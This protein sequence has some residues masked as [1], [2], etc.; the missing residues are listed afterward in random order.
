MAEKKGGGGGGGRQFRSQI[1]FYYANNGAR[2]YLAPG[3]N[4]TCSATDT[5]FIKVPFQGGG[6]SMSPHPL[7]SNLL[8]IHTRLQFC[9]ED[10]IILLVKEGRKKCFI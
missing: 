3:G 6:S 8:V 7:L 1:S 2:I 10:N 4:T 9:S 5:K